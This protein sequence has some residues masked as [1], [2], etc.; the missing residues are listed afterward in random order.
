MVRFKLLVN[1]YRLVEACIAAKVHY[2][3]LADGSEFVKGIAAFNESA[4]KAGVFV[5]SGVSSFPVL[6]AA[7]ARRLCSDMAKV[8]SIRGG[9]APSPYAASAKMSS[10]PS[11]AMPDRKSL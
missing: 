11:P 7:V 8:E 5:L 10:A 1:V 9:I 2:L 6:A 4:M 3:D